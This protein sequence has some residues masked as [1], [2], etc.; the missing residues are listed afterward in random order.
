MDVVAE[1]VK[2]ALIAVLVVLVPFLFMLI[3]DLAAHLGDLFGE[4]RS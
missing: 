4:R 2:L 1:V 3:F